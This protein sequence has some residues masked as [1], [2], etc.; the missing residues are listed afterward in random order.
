MERGI[1]SGLNMASVVMWFLCYNKVITSEK[2]LYIFSKT[3]PTAALIVSM[4]IRLIPKLI[5][6]SRIITQAQKSMGL[7]IEEGNVRYRLKSSLR[8]M[9]VL[10]TWALE[11]AVETADSMK[12]RGYG[13]KGRTSFS[14]Y[15]FISRDMIMLILLCI[16]SMF[17]TAGYMSGYCR[18]MFYPVIGMI[19]YD[20]LSVLIYIVYTAVCFAAVM[21]EIVESVRWRY[22]K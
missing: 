15:N 2:F 16:A 20:M 3:V 19:S 9:S 7:D 11:D 1:A 17:I 6:Q 14:L 8:I 4:T 21:L 10:V 5:N 13:L 18:L 12:A 22:L